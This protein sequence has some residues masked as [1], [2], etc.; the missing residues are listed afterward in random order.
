MGLQI[1]PPATIVFIKD[2]AESPED[3]AITRAII[4]MAHGLGLTVVAEGVESEE[5][6]AI[7]RHEGCDEVQGFLMSPAVPGERFTTMLRD[8]DLASSS[9]ALSGGEPGGD[10]TPA[11][12]SAAGSTRP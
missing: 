11:L 3:L 2:L 8:R 7:L 5:Q 9:P 12:V 10:E 1:N 4:T 6:L